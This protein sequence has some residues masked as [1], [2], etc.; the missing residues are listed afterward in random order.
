MKE[1]LGLIKRAN[2]EQSL[3]YC[4][5]LTRLAYICFVNRKYIESEKYFRI[6]GE[7]V[8]RVTK[9]PA[10]IFNAKRNILTLYTYSD[11]DKAE[12]YGE[13]M[14]LDLDDFLP[15]HNKEL[16][17]MM[18]NVNFLKGDRLKAKHLYRHGL[19]LAP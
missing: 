4:F 14:M 5:L 1:A 13:N 9:N 2:Q 18:G 15:A 12:K 7:L 3:G 10:S 17:L 8:P 11:I 16:I 19:K 6:C